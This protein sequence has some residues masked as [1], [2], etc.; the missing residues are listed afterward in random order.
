MKSA[1]A[2]VRLLDCPAHRAH[3]RDTCV[4]IQNFGTQFS[5]LSIVRFS[6]DGVIGRMGAPV[7]RLGK[8]ERPTSTSLAPYFAAR[9]SEI[10]MPI[11]PSP[12]V[13]RYTPPFRNDEQP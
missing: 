12:P 11:L 2:L 8:L 6:S 13:I 9:Y 5:S 1:K 7:F 4:H 10:A 3:I